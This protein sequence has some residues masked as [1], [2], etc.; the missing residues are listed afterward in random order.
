MRR[1]ALSLILL[2]ALAAH[3]SPAS[4]M[5]AAQTA[6]RVGALQIVQGIAV[7][8]VS[9]SWAR[10]AGA[11]DYVASRGR[12]FLFAIVQLKRQGGHDSYLVDPADFHVTTSGGD[13]LDSEQ[14]GV[15]GELLP[16][17]LYTRALSGVVGFEVPAN[18]RNLHLLWQPTL[19][20]SPDAQAEW[21]IGFGGRTV[22]YF[23]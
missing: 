1:I 21:G 7:R 16:R 9:V 8:L 3:A 10:E 23:R 18:D 11:A 6:P 19:T 4:T 15:A 22:Q 5:H 2:V 14:F 17:H 20:S 13:T 12:I